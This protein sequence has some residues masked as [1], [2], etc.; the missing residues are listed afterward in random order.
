[1]KKGSN[2][3]KSSDQGKSSRWIGRSI[4]EDKQK[5]FYDSVRIIE[6]DS[7]QI[8]RVGETVYFQSTG[9]LPFIAQIDSL[10]EEKASGNKFVNAKWFYRSQDVKSLDS[11][12]LEK[13]QHNTRVDIFLS[14]DKDENDV[15]SIIK[16]CKILF[17]SGDDSSWTKHQ[18]EKD[19]FLCRHRF[20]TAGLK[21]VKLKTQEVATLQELCL[22][23]NQ[24]V[25]GTKKNHLT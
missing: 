5:T 25:S 14:D 23:Q 7:S 24:T 17:F 19:T 9:A 4:R 11:K 16:H 18:H 10:Y 22:K 8:Y 2:S 21:I 12:V 13:I 6:D 1:M 20:I 3:K 15:L